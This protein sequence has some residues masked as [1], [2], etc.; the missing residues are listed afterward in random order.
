MH[1]STL[2]DQLQDDIS[3]MRMIPFESSVGG[4]QRMVRDIA[5]DLSKQVQLEVYSTALEL[6]K[7]V[8]DALKDPIMHLLRNAIDHGI[9]PPDEREKMGKSPVGRI[10]LSVEQRGGE[11]YVRVADDG[12][13]IDA[14]RVRRAAVKAGLLTEGMAGA[15][16][17][18]EA[19]L[20]IFHAGLTT[21]DRVTSVSGRGL[22][23]DIVR[24][25]VENMRG[26]VSMQSAN[27]KGT[28]ITLSVPHSL[29]AAACGQRGIRLALKH[30]CPHGADAAQ[31]R[32]YR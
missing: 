7:T 5:R 29:Y 27:S 17:D 15:L 6:D 31:R 16:S 19:R 23:M 30:G 32:V 21:S 1:L 4:F 8:L 13:G 22:G 10:D 24:D 2:A 26:R 18:D 14:E 9:E 11:I 28:I 25:R 3:R 20:I 12:R